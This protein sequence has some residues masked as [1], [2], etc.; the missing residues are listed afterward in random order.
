MRNE[1][2]DII[3]DAPL[4]VVPT[5]HK[6]VLAEAADL[7]GYAVHGEWYIAMKR[8]CRSLGLDWVGQ[9]Q[10]IMRDPIL[11]KGA[12]IIQAPSRGGAQELVALR[13]DL[14]WGW[15]FKLELSRLD[16]EVR[17]I[18]ISFQA[19]GY[20]ALH[21]HFTGRRND[22]SAPSRA[23]AVTATPPTSTEAFAALEARVAALEADHDRDICPSPDL[24]RS[25]KIIRRATNIEAIPIAGL[26]DH[27]QT[28]AIIAILRAAD[29]AMQ[30]HEVVAVMERA[31][32]LR[33]LPNQVSVNLRHMARRGRIRKVGR[34]FYIV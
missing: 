33:T 1:P 8:A 29:G 24:P 15:L 6:V 2:I 19:A 21:A 14:F 13:I 34:G 5:E 26:P 18:L 7:E 25:P 31:G 4:T 9:R 11:S 10:R 3:A 20:T 32:V 16:P 28:A 12:C 17:D 30:P 23:L 27:S 22:T